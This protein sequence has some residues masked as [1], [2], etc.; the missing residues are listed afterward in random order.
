MLLLLLKGVGKGGEAEGVREM[1]SGD[2]F[3]VVEKRRLLLPRARG[4]EEGGGLDGL[5]VV[6]FGWGGGE[7]GVAFGDGTAGGVGVGV[8]VVGVGDDAV[9]AIG[10]VAATGDVVAV[11]DDATDDVVVGAGGVEVGGPAGLAIDE[12]VA[13]P[14]AAGEA[15]GALAI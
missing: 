13:G 7:G 10:D 11:T 8:G 15:P 6:G 12:V 2:G 4:G 14:M 9:T 3:V 5:V 1:R